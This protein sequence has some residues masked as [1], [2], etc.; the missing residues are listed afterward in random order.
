MSSS[1]LEQTRRACANAEYTTRGNVSSRERSKL[2][3]N[4][5]G[6]RRRNSEQ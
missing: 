4:A 3:C 1:V 5:A 6:L 2:L